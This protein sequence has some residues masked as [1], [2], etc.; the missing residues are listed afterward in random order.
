MMATSDTTSRRTWQNVNSKRRLQRIQNVQ[1]GKDI[2][3]KRH[4]IYKLPNLCGNQLIGTLLLLSLDPL[5]LGRSLQQL[6]FE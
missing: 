1:E 4:K 5:F 3:R 2:R 6:N